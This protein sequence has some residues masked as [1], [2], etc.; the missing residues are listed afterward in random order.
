[1]SLITETGSG[2][3][4]ADSYLSLADFRTYCG[5]WGYDLGSTADAVLETKLRLATAYIDTNFRYKGV[6]LVSEQALE[7]PR[8]NLY[9]WSAYLVTGVPGRVAKACAELAFKSLTDSLYQDQDRGGKTVSQTVGPVS[10]SYA[11]DAPT[12]T[13]YQFASNLLA[14]YIRKDGDF[15]NPVFYST[16]DAVD[17]TRGEFDYSGA[18]YLHDPEA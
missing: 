2:L 6:R 1:M 18:D 17:F 4:D 9:D 10:V 5:K 16:S 13:V 7:F 3:A 11:A 8:D 12:G 15:L 14:P